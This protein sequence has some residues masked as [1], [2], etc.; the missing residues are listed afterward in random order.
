ML[1]RKPAIVRPGDQCHQAR[2]FP[3]LDLLPVHEIAERMDQ[4]LGAEIAGRG[5]PAGEA[6]ELGCGAERLALPSRSR[7]RSL[8]SQ[9][10]D[11]DARPAAARRQSAH[12]RGWS[13]ASSSASNDPG[14]KVGAYS[15]LA[16]GGRLMSTLSA[17]ALVCSPKT[18]PRS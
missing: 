12:A 13:M 14:A 1:V 18:V 6:G 2:A 3:A 10:Q 7:G 11:H 5:H 17:R 4:R 9:E 15:Q 16:S 8:Q